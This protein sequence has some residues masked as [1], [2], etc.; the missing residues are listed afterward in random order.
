MCICIIYIY[1]HYPTC[2]DHRCWWAESN[3]SGCSRLDRYP[4]IASSVFAIPGGV[5][6]ELFVPYLLVNKIGDALKIVDCISIFV[7]AMIWTIVLSIHTFTSPHRCM[8]ITH[9][10]SKNKRWNNPIASM[11]GTWIFTFRHFPL[12]NVA[13][14]SPTSCRYTRTHT[15]LIGSMYGI[16]LSITFGLNLW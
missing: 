9:V 5:T 12:F 4:M 13:I 11:Y 16:Y 2:G 8:V 15:V 10:L 1:C 7:D 3:T 14:S 6:V